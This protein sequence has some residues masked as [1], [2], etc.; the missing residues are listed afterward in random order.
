MAYSQQNNISKL[1]IDKSPALLAQDEASYLLNNERGVGG[2]KGDLGHS[3]PMPANYPAGLLT[4]PGGENY[5]VGGSKENITN[6]DYNFVFNSNGAHYLQRVSDAGG[7]EII[8]DKE[9]LLLSADPQYKITPE[10]AMLRLDEVYNK[11]EVICKNRHG[12]Q[13]IWTDGLNPIG[14]IDTEASI[15]TDGFTTPFF[16]ICANPCAM[17]QLCVP[18][19]CGAITGEFIARTSEDAGL[20]NK[21]LQLSFKFRV[22]HIYYD[23]RAS[24]WSD[25]SIPFYIDDKGCFAGLDALSRCIQIKVPIGNPMVERIEL[26]FS[27]GTLA[28]DGN[29]EVW[30][31]YDTIEKYKKYNSSQEKWY[32]RALNDE[33][34]FDLNDCTLEYAFCNDKDCI[35]ID[36]KE[37]SR[38]YNPLPGQPQGILRLKENNFGFYN[39]IQ[40]NCPVDKIEIDKFK[41]SIECPADVCETEL[42]T[43]KVRLV[44]ADV[45]NNTV[46]FVYR[47]NGVVGGEDDK[48]DKAYYGAYINGSA[49]SI[50]LPIKD[51][52]GQSF[53]GDRNFVAYIEGTDYFVEM[54]QWA[55]DNGF[56]N[57]REYGIVSGMGAEAFASRVVPQEVIDNGYFYQEAIFKVPKGSAGIIRLKAPSSKLNDASTSAPIRGILPL[58]ALFTSSFGINNAFSIFD[59]RMELEFDT[60]DGDVEFN[61]AFLIQSVNG[62]KDTFQVIGGTNQD[63]YFYTGYVTDNNGEPIND[64]LVYRGN[65]GELNAVTDHNGYYNYLTTEATPPAEYRVE[66]DCGAFKP[67]ESL[68]LNGNLNGVAKYDV[69]ITNE[70]YINRFFYKL[71]VSVLDCNDIAISG[72]TIAATGEK[73]QIT[74]VSNGVAT[75]KIRNKQSRDKKVKAYVMDNGRCFVVAC[76]GSCNPCMPKTDLISLIPCFSATG[77]QAD[78][79]T[80]ERVNTEAAMVNKR[81]LKRGGSYPLG[82]V[83]QGDCAKLSAVYELPYLE[84]PKMQ[85]TMTSGG[86]LLSFDA[87]GFKAP[88]GFN[89]LKVVRGENRN[90]Y[91]IQWQIDKIE[92]T[93]GKVLLTIQSLNDY[94]EFYLFETNTVYQWLKGDR[95]EFIRDQEGKIIDASIYG[96]LNYLTISPFAETLLVNRN[97]P[98]AKYFN[99]LVIEDD[100]KLGFLK[101]GAVIEI[102]RAK[103]CT[104]EP[105]YFQIFSIPINIDGSL[106]IE[107]GTFESFDTYAKNRIIDGVF[108]MFE[109]HSPSDFWGTRLT[110]AGKVYFKNLYENERRYGRNIS[111]NAVGQ[112]NYFGDLVKTM[113]ATQQ[114]DIIAM[115]IADGKVILGICE[116]DNFVAMSANDLLRLS[117]TGTIIANPPDAI[118]GNPEAKISGT[119]GCRYSDIGSVYFGDGYATWYDGRNYCYV[120]HDYQIAKAVDYGKVQSYFRTIGAKMDLLNKAATDLDKA[121]FSVGF[122]YLT[123]AVIITNKSLRQAGF[124]NDKKLYDSPNSTILFHPETNDFLTM[125]GYTAESYSHVTLNDG[126]GCA[127]L[128]YYNGMPFIHPVVP[129]KWNEFFGVATDR[130]MVLVINKYQQKERVPLTFEVQSDT[131]YYVSNVETSDTNFKSEIPPSKVKQFGKKWNASFLKNINSVGGLFNGKEAN[132]YWIKVTFVRDNTQEINGKPVYGSIDN[133]KRVKFDS[134]SL[135]FFRFQ[136][137]EQSGFPEQ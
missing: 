44:I 10:R 17:V 76:D 90:S 74:N 97:D 125:A 114:G 103:E 68:T 102:Q 130:V 100:G 101:E 32:E 115:S 108:Q 48:T 52:A 127:F 73:A 99:Q 30:K 82:L 60:C 105:I 26:A 59:S 118:I 112:F 15:A 96:I 54:K 86:C 132:D 75:F 62:Y 111:I 137:S 16:D 1:N 4:Q 21:L 106:A 42:A 14:C 36:P 69:K 79:A 119:Y 109:H 23:L 61:D 107:Q 88:E 28:D 45:R 67:L 37:T 46:Q 133:T 58:T 12:K 22:R 39:Y 65:T 34:V 25:I 135:V 20:S 49:A 126:F 81:H 116:N 128:S 123:G 2:N 85:K 55:A 35:S 95:V 56:T 27:N 98:N 122:N 57:R 131:M 43:I 3:N 33:Y 134:L 71:N 13:Y 110:D 121:R 63:E 64:L 77:I 84:V 6:E 117:N 66:Q 7:L 78:V 18:E 94:N 31:L 136:M 104:T 120:K 11:N 41:V 70:D 124:N 47:K 29:N 9:C 92:R 93:D 51:M 5:S 113:P 38:V 87:T 40:G 19:I 129:E 8:Y 24:E 83:L 89:C 80:N 53:N 91:Q 72:V 50:V